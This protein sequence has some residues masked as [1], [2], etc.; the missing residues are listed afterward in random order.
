VIDLDGCQ[1]N[2]LTGV[3]TGYRV[4][5]AGPITGDLVG[6]LPRF[7]DAEDTLRAAGHT[8]FNPA[9]L[10]GAR[11]AAEAVDL[12]LDSHYE[13]VDFMRAGITGLMRCNAIATLPG[14]WLSRGADLEQRLASSLGYA[15]ISA[16]N[17]RIVHDTGKRADNMPGELIG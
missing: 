13:W 4:Y 12:A 16:S 14:W 6:N 10:G 5:I 2:S 7:F 9:R 15:G 3:E 1:R 11:T 17:G 8:T